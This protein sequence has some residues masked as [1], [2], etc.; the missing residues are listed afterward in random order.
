M[1]VT[2]PDSLFML[3][4]IFKDKNCC[5][6]YIYKSKRGI[7]HPK[8]YAS[9][10]NNKFKIL[11]GSANLTSGGLTNNIEASMFISSK[12]DDKYSDIVKMFER[13]LL[14][15]NCKK[16]NL[17]NLHQYK[18]DYDIYSKKI[19]NANQEV[20]IELEKKFV[21]DLDNIEEF[22][23]EYLANE[24]VEE[25]WESRKKDYHEAKR[26]LDEMIECNFQSS[27]EFMEY[28]GLLVGTAGEGQLWHSGSI[29]RLK[30]IV[31]Q[32]F[33]LFMLMLS[34]LKDSIGASPEELFLI[35]KPYVS[36]ID[37]LGYNVVTEILN[38]YGSDKYPILNNNPLDSIKHLGFSGFKK[39]SSFNQSDYQNFSAFMIEFSKEVGFSNL[40]QVDHFMNYIYWKYVKPNE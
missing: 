9:K 8:I 4:N 6:L 5:N 18:K 10:N 14:S 29:N 15:K 17:L 20:S 19:T 36:E 23:D 13:L 34:D 33:E 26:L 21:L 35:A 30:N 28:Y 12:N 7:F 24:D 2:D 32:N 40:M 37:G 25:E 27:D 39:A 22:V 3:Y 31:S 38:T 11:L 1:F 16:S